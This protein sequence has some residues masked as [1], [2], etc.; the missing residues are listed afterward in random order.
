[1]RARCD[2]VRRNA[3][4]YAWFVN[5]TILSIA[6]DTLASFIR[7]LRACVYQLPTS[8]CGR[9]YRSIGHMHGMGTVQRLTRGQV[10]T[11]T[12]GAGEW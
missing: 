8:T 12:A 5:V 7:A 10:P 1:M 3:W 11:K 6:G 4:A 2:L 9:L